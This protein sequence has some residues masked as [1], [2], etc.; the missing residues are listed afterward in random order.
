MHPVRNEE[1]IGHAETPVDLLVQ[2]DRARI[3]LVQRNRVDLSALSIV[4]NQITPHFKLSLTRVEVRLY[5]VEEG[6]LVI[7]GELELR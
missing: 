3:Q 4:K 6:P 2:A 1:Q 5:R 7:S